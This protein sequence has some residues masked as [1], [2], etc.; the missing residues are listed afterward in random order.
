MRNNLRTKTLL[1]YVFLILIPFTLLFV[2]FTIS[3]VKGIQ[4]EYILFMNDKNSKLNQRINDIISDIDR[5][6]Y[7]NAMNSQAQTILKKRYKTEGAEYNDDLNV[8]NDLIKASNMF[9]PY[10]Y[11]IIYIANNGNVFSNSAIPDNMKARIS[12]WIPKAR[13]MRGKRIITDVYTIPNKGNYI[14]VFHMIRNTGTFEEN[15]FVFI[16]ISLDVIKNVLEKNSA[17]SNEASSTI[18]VTGNDIVYQSQSDRED[19]NLLNYTTVEKFINNW[20]K[21]QNFTDSIMSPDG[22][23]LVVGTV[24]EVTQW[25]TIQFISYS[26]INKYIKKSVYFY[27]YIMI[28]FLL[29]LA[30]MGY[31]LTANILN[32][33]ELLKKAMKKVENGNWVKVESKIKGQEMD[34]LIR[35]YNQMVDQLQDSIRQIFISEVNQKKIE[36]KMLESQIN[37][38]FLYNTLNLI[39]SMAEIEG[40]KEISAVSDNLSSMFRYNIQ[41]SSIVQIYEELTQIKN[42]VSIQKLR[43]KEKIDFQ[44]NINDEIKQYY[45]L[46]FLL[47][48]IIENAIYHG[49]EKKSGKCELLI[50]IKEED[51]NLE[52]VVKDSG[53]GMSEQALSNLKDKINR[54]RENYFSLDKYEHIGLENVYFRI[55]DYYGEQ[56]GLQIHSKEGEWTEV[57]IVIPVVRER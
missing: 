48:P 15:G 1:L 46:K 21:A 35:T 25:K 6:S 31:Y 28:P 53:I 52:I 4:N 39:S 43:F 20:G 41:Q 47:Q 30:I 33:I 11:E 7:L 49:I 8:M 54:R 10:F 37:P 3:S 27:G 57:K 51:Q 23:M 29:M 36:F 32:P 24:N 40:I 26:T 9:N 38:H 55:K 50:T 12:D 34:G 13:Q 17:Q 19:Y 22:K 42:Y 18:I 14:S 56:Y 44:Y 5:V 45:M 16:N 2:S